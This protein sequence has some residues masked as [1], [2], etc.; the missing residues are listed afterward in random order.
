M[1]PAWFDGDTHMFNQ[2]QCLF[3]AVGTVLFGGSIWITSA[4]KQMSG[5]ETAAAEQGAK[6]VEPVA[7]PKIATAETEFDF[8][9]LDVAGRCEHDFVVK[10]EGN[11]P[12]QL[13]SG[14]TT[15]KCTMSDL[16]KDPIMPGK[17]ANICVSSKLKSK[18]GFFKHSASI[19]TNDPNNE[20]I[21][22]TIK[23]TIRTHLG[24]DP[25]QIIF[26]DL[27]PN[28]SQSASVV[29]Y[30]QVWRQFSL[31][32]IVPSSKL[33]TWKIE[34]AS[35]ETLNALQARAGYQLHVTVSSGIPRGNF[36]E[37]L[38]MVGRPADKNIKP[39]SLTIPITG[40]VPN[41]LSVFGRKLSARKVLVIGTLSIGQGARELL[42][43]KIRDDHR[44]LN[45]KRI[46][47]VPDFLN[48]K[49]TP[50]S[51]STAAMGLYKIDVEVP[52][53]APASDYMSTEGKIRIITDHPHVPV[54][55]LDV[56]FAVT[57][58]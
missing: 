48:V 38:K 51:E 44:V 27:E 23:G 35:K 22:L 50:Y 40:K 19:L 14:M 55:T 56:E 16:P 21:Q 10:N 47:T 42:T 2:Y 1:P 9:F 49:V 29:V 26:A 11:A 43:M 20:T 18:P 15:C 30:S 3:I 13:V 8:G 53:N 34:P 58:T 24:T 45:V 6:C 36:W 12:L 28:K 46:E 4:E 54:I 52:K 41:R 57:G 7:V 17:R 5:T 32:N 39:K 37:S 25:A 31:D 33:I